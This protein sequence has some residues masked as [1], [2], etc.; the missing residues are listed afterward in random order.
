[1]PAPS[2]PTLSRRLVP[3]TVTALV[4]S[5]LLLLPSTAEAAPTRDGC[6]DRDNN[7]YA[8]ILQCVGVNGIRTHQAEFQRIA[9]ANDDPFYPG[10]RAAGT[11]CPKAP[12]TG[13]GRRPRTPPG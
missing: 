9:E 1:M 3:A 5:A 11:T 10:T 8:K 6:L 13:S 12:P 2:L 7:T 4:A